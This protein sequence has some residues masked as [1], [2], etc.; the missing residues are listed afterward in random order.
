M[1]FS[2]ETLNIYNTSIGQIAILKFPANIRPSTGLILEN[3]SGTKWRIIGIG[4]GIKGRAINYF[5]DKDIDNLWDCKLQLFSGN[6]SLQ[7]GD[8]LFSASPYSPSI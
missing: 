8:V 4:M 6:G 1:R 2:I 5:E 7:K 3:Q